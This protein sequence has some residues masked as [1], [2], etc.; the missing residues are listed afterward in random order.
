MRPVS[1]FAPQ[2]LILM[3]GPFVHEQ[4]KALAPV[5]AREPEPAKRVG[6]LYRRAVGRAPSADELKLALAFLAEQAESVRAQKGADA[7]PRALA[8]LC[9]VVFNT[10]EF[11]YL[12]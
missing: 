1:T 8:N 5:L 9:V 2:A 11:V 10:H 7:E 3:N 4:A 12:P 6:A